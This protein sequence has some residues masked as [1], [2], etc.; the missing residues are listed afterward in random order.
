MKH[1]YKIVKKMG[2]TIMTYRVYKRW[3]FGLL[4]QEIEWG[5]TLEDAEKII[6]SDRER[7]K[8]KKMK[9]ELIGYY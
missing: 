9:P 1:E 2:H 3:F 6:A 8:K 5:V 7:E 4:W